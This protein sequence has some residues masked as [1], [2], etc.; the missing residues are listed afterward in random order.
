MLRAEVV[1]PCILATQWR[2]S[3]AYC[4]SEPGTQSCYVIWCPGKS[5]SSAVSS[6]LTHHQTCWDFLP[7]DLET[8]CC[9][10]M[11]SPHRGVVV[12]MAVVITTMPHPSQKCWTCRKMAKDPPLFVYLFSPTGNSSSSWSGILTESL[13][14]NIMNRFSRFWRQVLCYAHFM[15]RPKTIWW[16]HTD[17]LSRETGLKRG[18]VHIG[19]STLASLWFCWYFSMLWEPVVGTSF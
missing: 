14:Q 10:E 13:M 17:V 11:L 4:R 2:K 5:V 7:N 19:I 12:E 8:W 3:V 6:V 18:M 9:R 1:E 15:L 16:I